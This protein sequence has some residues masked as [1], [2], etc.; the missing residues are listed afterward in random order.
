MNQ[1]DFGVFEEILDEIDTAD[2]PRQ[3]HLLL[4]QMYHLLNSKQ[5][6]QV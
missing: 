2:S 6:S 3:L 5:S 4:Q 1:S